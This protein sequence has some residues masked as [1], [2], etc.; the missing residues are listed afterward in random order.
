MGGNMFDSKS[1]E[2][3]GRKS[4]MK[5]QNSWIIGNIKNYGQIYLLPIYCST[6]VLGVLSLTQPKIL[7]VSHWWIVMYS[8]ENRTAGDQPR[9]IQGIRRRDG[10][11]EDQE[12]IA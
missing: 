6:L 5:S 11:G 3:H 2:S 8:E 12:T 10:V 4:N 9:L 7:L 1:Y